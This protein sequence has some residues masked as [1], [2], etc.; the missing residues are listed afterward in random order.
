MMKKPAIAAV[1]LC[2]FLV[3]SGS[4]A[5]AQTPAT[6]APSAPANGS[7]VNVPFTISWTATLDPSLVNGGY[8]WQ[9][10]RSSTFA[11]LVM[12][13]STKPSITQDVVSGLTPA[14]YFWRVQAVNGAG[15]SAWS[16]AQSF[17][18]M[19]V[20]AGAPGTPVL[21]PTQGYSTFHPWESIVFHWSV[22]PDAVTYR[23]EVSNDPDFPVG[24]YPA[25][26]V[27]F[28]NDNI[29]TNRDGYVHTMIG[30]WYAR[31]FAIDADNPQEGVRGQPSNVIQFS[32]FY[33]NPIGPPPE[34]ISPLDNPTLKL[35]VTLSWAHVPNP[36]S[37]GY[38]W[39][40]AT[41]PGFNNIEAFN[42]QYT[43]P[44]AVMLSLTSG[45]KYWRVLS[46]HGLS[47]PTTN[48][49]TD[50]SATGQFTISSDPA[51]PVS[52]AP[53]GG[54]AIIYSGATRNVALQLTAAVPSNGATV[55][56]S[57]SHPSLVPL[58]S[59]LSMLGGH[60]YVEFLVKAGQVTTATAVTLT[61]TL[62][63][64]TA[65]SVVTVRP[66]TLDNEFVHPSVR[67]TGGSPLHAW[68]SLEGGG[69]A[70][71]N[72][73][74]VNLS[75]SSNIATPPATVTIPAGV[76]GTGFQIQTS[77]VSATT[78]VTI[79]ASA[80][81]VTSSWAVTITPSPAPADLLVRPMSTTKGSQGTVVVN[82]GLGQDQTL[83]VSS[84]NPA[85]AAV[86]N[87]V[88]VSAGSGVGFFNITT[89]AVAEPTQV[90]I[91][92]SGGG[93]TL[94]HPLTLYPALPAMTS[95]TVNPG[96]VVGG[97]TSTGTITLAGPAPAVGVHVNL[98]ASQPNS[99]SVPRSVFVPSGATNATF[100]ITT[101]ASS[102]TNTVQLSAALDGA[103]LSSSITVTPAPS[104][105]SL[106]SLTVN[107]TS[108][109]GGNSAT[110]TATLSAAAPSGGA[111]V[112]LSDNSSA[113]TVPASVTV[114]AGA[115]SANFSITTST[116]TSATSAT[117][118]AAFGG[119]TRTASLTV[120][121]P[122]TTPAAPSLVSP[123][124]RATVAQPVAFDWSD[125]ANAATYT[126]QIDTS[127]NFT[128]PLTYT[129]SVK[130]SNTSVSGLPARE[131]FWRVRAV[132]A[133]GTAGPFSSSRRFTA[134][135]TTTAPALSSLS[136]S[137]TSIV[138]G[139]TATGTVS[140]T[141]AA[142]TG[143]LNVSLA[144]SSTTVASVPASVTVP[145]GAT[146][147][148]F[149]ITTTAVSTSTSVTITATQGS[150]TR[151]ATLSVAPVPPAATLS[152]LSVS[153]ASVSGG[154]GSTG[155]VSLTSAAP[156]GGVAVTLS[157][158][159]AAAA[160]PAT[161]N[162]AAGATTAQFAITTTTVAS[163]TAVTITASNGGVNRTATLTV[164]PQSTPTTLPAPSLLAP[165][166]DAQF[167]PGSTI[168]FDWGEV[169]GAASYII[170]IDDSDT[171]PSPLIVNQTTPGSQFA[172]STLPERRMWWRVRAVDASGTLG[173]WSAVR[174]FEVKD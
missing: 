115:S 134:Q 131:L 133:A 89:A 79:S 150:T 154:S 85:L 104:S 70:G 173:A 114:P 169:T 145:A 60:A 123:A 75:S 32:A 83:Q 8:N 166:S 21:E 153:P 78:V 99:A 36:Q 18:V 66:P 40:V 113:T 55:A 116:V 88:L 11:P 92:V 110:G 86:P 62:N 82:E 34:L 172:T 93:V 162:V 140:L 91:S 9:V 130:L 48:A 127:S 161:V 121:P 5:A 143:G 109:A 26:T 167:A 57:S 157:S 107:P 111:V 4:R 28:W 63:G 138:G 174:R 132:N 69:L 44:L 100:P 33:D 59:T 64:V 68:V 125:V 38:L 135:S 20:G 49:V 119:T 151:T 72:G 25:G 54:P 96:T 24:N 67:T 141:S 136:V 17:T 71:P 3:A 61:A 80:N 52:I 155:T 168:N 41:D 31:V 112:S 171:F 23:L 105:A 19:G 106:S 94:S 10:S 122:T 47:S 170:Q 22:V 42:N 90:T 73:F 35:P 159:N 144:S 15:A 148:N 98:G 95:L 77:P 149:A 87:T 30:N 13:D 139:N 101:F 146:S 137:P 27:T 152:G 1:A 103:F 2:V 74:V 29:P 128:T 46:Q 7:A 126:I 43:N 56:L 97:A 65:S 164:N 16:E 163:A 160:V 84:S 118:T 14:T 53:T 102:F 165:S 108:V 76:S 58:P 156:S 120:N 6:P 45:Q 117:I 81:G 142:T 12:A 50:W 124:N 51:T 39:E 37:S 129:S 147:A 158:S